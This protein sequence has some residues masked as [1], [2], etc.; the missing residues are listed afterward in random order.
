MSSADYQASEVAPLTQGSALIAAERRRQITQEGWTPDHDDG[1]Q[2]GELAAA[3]ACYAFAAQEKVSPGGGSWH[4]D[5]SWP[6][7][8]EWWKPSEDPVR[9]LVKAGALIAAE[10]DRLLRLA[11][12]GGAA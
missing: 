2:A 6:W 11:E 5:D 12:K 9:N 4:P 7:S 3:A 10:I 1:H 8:E